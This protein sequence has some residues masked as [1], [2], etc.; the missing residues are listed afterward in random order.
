MFKVGQRVL[1]RESRDVWIIAAESRNHA[2]EISYRLASIRS[3]APGQP[4]PPFGD[5]EPSE[6][7]GV[8]PH[9]IEPV[10]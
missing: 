7:W 2:G 3:R 8:R 4:L 5:V 9:E 10:P 1:D 6:R